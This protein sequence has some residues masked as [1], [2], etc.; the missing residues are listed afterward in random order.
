[1]REDSFGPGS[2]GI[3]PVHFLVYIAQYE[4]DFVLCPICSMLKPIY[5]H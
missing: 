2:T 4:E 3:N 5:I 1:M